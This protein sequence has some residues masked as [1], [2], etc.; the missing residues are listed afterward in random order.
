MGGPATRGKIHPGAD[1]NASGTAGL[2]ELSRRYGAQKNRQG[3]RLVFIAFSAEEKGLE[4]SRHYCQEPLLPLEKTVAMLNM[5]IVGRTRPVDGAGTQDRLVVYGTGT[6]EGFDKLVDKVGARL[7][8]KLLKNPAGTGPSDHDSFYRQKVPVL[9]LYTGG[10][11]DYHRPTDLPEKINVPGLKKVADFAEMVANDLLTRD[12]RPKFVATKA[13]WDDPTSPRPARP[14][15]ARLGIRPSSASYTG[16]GKGVELEDVTP[17]G[18]AD[19]AGIKKGDVIVEIG[20][21][22]TPH[23][24]AYMSAMA[25]QKPGTTVEVVV[26]RMGKSLTLKAK[27]E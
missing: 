23:I 18:A 26:E 19:K 21:K 9:F 7:D 27:L 24:G 2:L 1:D 10:H 4:G 11:S 12:P 16:T 3:R 20:G 8:F 15:G 17:G 5:D 14:Q 13:P 22:P 6:S 25:T